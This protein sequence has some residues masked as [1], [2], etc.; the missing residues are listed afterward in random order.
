MK[1]LVS[2]LALTVLGV[3]SPLTLVRTKGQVENYIEKQ[4]SG[5]AYTPPKG[6]AERKSILD[7]L[8][9]EVKR[10]HRIEPVFVVHHLKVQRGWAWIETSPQSSEGASRY[11]GISALLHKSGGRWRVAEIACAEEENPNCL[12]QRDFFSRLMKRF[13]AAPPEIFP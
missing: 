9:R 12:G 2:M 3:L 10:L 4:Q 5:S 1:I 11:E 7:T 8:R 6:S 13:P